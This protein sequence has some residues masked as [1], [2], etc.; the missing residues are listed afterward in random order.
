MDR[1]VMMLLAGMAG[2]LLLVACAGQAGSEQGEQSEQAAAPAPRAQESAGESSVQFVVVAFP[3][4]PNIQFA[5]YYVA[6]SKG[7]YADEGLEVD[8]E[9]M[10]ENEAVQVVAQGG[11][12]FGYLNGISVMLARQN[13][14]PVVTVATVT[15]D[16]PVVF[17]SKGSTPLASVD[18]LKGKRIGYPGPFGASYYGLQALLYSSSVQESELDLQDI[19]F[20]QVEMVL[21][22]KVDVAVGYAMNEP[23]QLRAMD[24][25]V[26]V[27][28]VADYY[29][30]VS[31]GIITTEEMI[32]SNAA[33]VQSFVIATLRGLRDTLANPEEA[34]TLSLEYIPEAQLGD[35]SFQR[36]VLEATLPYWESERPGYSNPVV[37]Q[38]TRTFLLDRELL[39]AE[40]SLDASMTNEFIK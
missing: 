9:Y 21:E 17:F 25:E 15:Q 3:Y 24:E 6:S 8:F 35:P 26:N 38:Q 14:L 7:Y 40:V 1:R 12:D 27:L 16:F 32:T 18:D 22:D 5:P 29:P 2:L 33:L 30:L 37:W 13:G 10:Y 20:N 34:F 39:N 19:G 4:I 36:E 31:D 11:A 23:V 28:R